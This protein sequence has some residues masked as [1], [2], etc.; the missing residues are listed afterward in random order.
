MVGMAVGIVILAVAAVIGA[1]VLQ[2]MA[3]SVGCPALYELNTTAN[4]CN[5]IANDSSAELTLNTAGTSAIYSVGYLGSSTGGLLTWLP[6]II[7]AIIGIAII[8]YFLVLRRG[9]RG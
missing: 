2:T 9:G 6:V 4:T 8:G 1:V 5:E 7:P 3:G